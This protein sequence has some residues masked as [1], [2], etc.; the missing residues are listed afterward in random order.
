M[1]DHLIAARYVRDLLAT[2]GDFRFD[3][4]TSRLEIA[5]WAFARFPQVNA[6]YNEYL[7]WEL[8]LGSYS[9]AMWIQEFVV[10]HTETADWRALFRQNNKLARVCEFIIR[11]RP[12]IDHHVTRHPHSDNLLAQEALL[13]GANR[14][15]IAHSL[16]GIRY[17]GDPLPLDR[18]PAALSKYNLGRGT[19]ITVHNG[20]DDALWIDGTSFVE[21][22]STKAYPH[23]DG[24]VS[25]LHQHFPGIRIVQLGTTTSRPISGVD[26]DLLN[27]TTIQESAAI[28]ADS[29]LHID[30]ESGLVHLAACAGVKSCVL[31]GPTSFEF[32]SYEGNINIP[33]P[34][35]GNC[36]WL[37]RDW[38]KVCARG[39]AIPKCL[40]DTP[41]E[42]VV[43]SVRPHLEQ[44]A[45]SSSSSSSSST[46]AAAAA[47]DGESSEPQPAES[48]P[49]IV[50]APDTWLG[51]AAREILAL[52]RP[53][54]VLGG[55]L[56]RVGRDQDGGYVMLE[57][58]LSEAVAYS[59]GI[60]ADI[61]WDA[62]MAARGCQVFQYDH[63]I[64]APPAAYERCHFFRIGL[65][66][67][68]SPDGTLR[69]LSD[70]IAANGHSDRRD[71]VL[72]MDIEGAEW[73][74]LPALTDQ[75]MAQ[76]S[77]VVVELHSV[78]AIDRPEELRRN[79]RALQRI[80]RTH[81]PVHVH[82]NNCGPI[83]VY[84]GVT[85]PDTLEVTY[86]RR[87]DHFFKDC[88]RCFPT[89]LDKPNNPAAADYFLGP[90]GL[91]AACEPAGTGALVGASRPSGG[92]AAAVES[93][94]K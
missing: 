68:T 15:N 11:S 29:R 56:V 25:L 39:H 10:L 48:A 50:S 41:P 62:D 1:G 53:M 4:Y 40:S 77:Q 55:R 3:I 57:Q 2:V 49:V 23:F 47:A 60:G 22:R 85:L 37:T 52:V 94:G 8:N 87:E 43:E 74:V 67:R 73:A 30:G 93:V 44:F 27:K 5:E 24:V 28:I 16:S 79:V 81:Q 78:I 36:W 13:R 72:K 32:F 64:A 69:T 65:A 89:P 63:T 88:E 38:M 26:A 90:L 75:T 84:G 35:C 46:A 92:D 42:K 12:L 9:L 91:V 7:E 33:P 51:V 70:I 20:S 61:S 83:G 80:N 66:E 18:N 86:A 21:G 45:F 19:Y 31:F 58:G 54:D 71:I 17:G 34:Y 82:A 14:C 6:F 76:L 59:I